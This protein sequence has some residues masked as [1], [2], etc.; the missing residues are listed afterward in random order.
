MRHTIFASH[1]E[2]EFEFERISFQLTSTNG[3]PFDLQSYM[4]AYQQFN[5]KIME[6]VGVK[7]VTFGNTNL[8]EVFDL[9][10]T[11]L[12]EVLMQQNMAINQDYQQHIGLM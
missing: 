3:Q 7:N 9:N 8:A 5:N 12:M 2:F 10:T 4:S 11:A 1:I 6:L